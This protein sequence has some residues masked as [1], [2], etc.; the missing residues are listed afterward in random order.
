M[1]KYGLILSGGSGIRMNS[2]T[3]KCLFPI[4]G[5]ELILYCLETFSNSSDIDSIVLVTNEKD[6]DSMKDLVFKSKLNKVIAVIKGS[7]SREESMYEGIKYINSISTSIDDI[8]LI[9]DGDRPLVSKQI[10][11]NNIDECL[12][13]KAC[14]TAIK[15]T[16]SLVKVNDNKIVSSIN[17]EE[18]Y[19]CQTPQ[20]FNLSILNRAIDTTI[21][22]LSEFTDEAGLLA[23]IGMN[24]SIVEGNPNNIKITYP[25]DLDIFKSIL[26]RG[27][28]E[29]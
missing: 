14:V 6:M 26:E 15:V 27:Q 24:P 16:N 25:S 11:K 17:R 23:S 10:I 9:H 4:N 19:S 13:T 28:Y 7:T 12:K 18:I 29:K 8:V 20:T 2:N 21:N 22:N 5:K 1:T 3:S